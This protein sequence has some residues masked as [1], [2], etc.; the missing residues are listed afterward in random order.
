MTDD[1]YTHDPDA[2]DERGERVDGAAGTADAGGTAGGDDG[3]DARQGWVVVALVAVCFVVFPLAVFL[4]P[5]EFLG[6][7]D[8]YMVTAMVPGLLL[9]LVGLWAVAKG[10]G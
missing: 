2:F 5:P 7:E 4:R 8:A 1:A 3:L 9:G 6:F 10:R